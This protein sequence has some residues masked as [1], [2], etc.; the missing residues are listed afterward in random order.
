MNKESITKALTA[1]KE[2]KKRNFSQSIDLVINLRDI[3]LKKSDNHV[4]F[5]MTLPKATG[6]KKKIGALVGAELI[7]DARTVCDTAIHQEEFTAFAKDKKKT[8]KLAREN[9]FFIAQANIMPKVASA[10]GKVL[11]SRGKMPNPK[12]GC[13]VPPKTALKPLY[14]KLQNTIKITAK[15]VPIIQC[16]VGT[17]ASTA[18]DII[19]NVQEIFKQLESKLPNGKNNIKNAYLK[20]TMGKPVKI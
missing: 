19:E 15:T 17:E 7:D 9:S 11:G 20:L 4:D 2:G 1:I 6:R 8:K 12:A 13:V 18:E 5:F 14:E 10:F 3:D 16:M